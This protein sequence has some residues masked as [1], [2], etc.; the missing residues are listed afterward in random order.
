MAFLTVSFNF[1]NYKPLGAKD[2]PCDFRVTLLK[3]SSNPLG[4]LRS[5][6]RQTFVEIIRINM[7]RT[8]NSRDKN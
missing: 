8:D 2:I 5:K 3:N 1:Q 6:G 4:V 7:T